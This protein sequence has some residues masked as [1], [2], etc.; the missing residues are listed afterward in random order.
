MKSFTNVDKKTKNLI[1]KI[2]LIA[3]DF[4]GVF[5]DNKVFVFQDGTEAVACYRGDGIGLNKLKEMDIH[6]RIISSEVN[7]VVLKRAEKLNIEAINNVSDKKSAL[8]KV[9]EKLK[10]TKDQVAFVGNDINDLKCMN[11]V[12]LPITVNDAHPDI[13]NHALYK[14]SNNGGAGAVREICDLFENVNK[15]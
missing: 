11:F 12:G 13:L 5:T 6:I 3:F 14:T 10:I 7:Q 2:R 15:G 1:K 8:V 4:D 9:I